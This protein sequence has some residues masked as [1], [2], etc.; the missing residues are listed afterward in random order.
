MDLVCPL[1]SQRLLLKYGLTIE[2]EA[3]EAR[4]TTF[5]GNLFSSCPLSSPFSSPQSLCSEHCVPNCGSVRQKFLSSLS[6]SAQ[7]R[8]RS[9][10][11]KFFQ[12]Q[13][14]T[15]LSKP[16]GVLLLL[17]GAF[18][19]FNTLLHTLQV[20]FGSGLFDFFDSTKHF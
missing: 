10:M 14:Y 17:I 2:E 7:L 9:S 4:F 13:C 3:Q 6:G 1:C 16:W 5:E 15:I 18:W 12:R 8:P 11:Q 20:V 19:T